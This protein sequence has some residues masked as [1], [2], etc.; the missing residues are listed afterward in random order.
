MGKAFSS[1]SQLG[2]ESSLG[3]SEGIVPEQTGYT[4]M[5]QNTSSVSLGPSKSTTAGI[6][7][8]VILL[9]VLLAGGPLFWRYKKRRAC[10]KGR[11][12]L[13][14]TDSHSTFGGEVKDI[15]QSAAMAVAA[16]QQQDVEKPTG[17]T[18]PDQ[19]YY[20]A[21]S[22]YGTAVTSPE[23]LHGFA[24]DSNI[25]SSHFSTSSQGQSD[26]NGVLSQYWVNDSATREE[27]IHSP[28]PMSPGNSEDDRTGSIL[29]Y[30]HSP[31]RALA[32][33]HLAQVAD[34]RFD[35][36]IASSTPSFPTTPVSASNWVDP[37]SAAFYAAPQPQSARVVRFASGVESMPSV[38]Y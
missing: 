27:R 21:E 10:R 11:L 15:Q 30:T 29:A 2:T 5:D 19:Y 16:E 24:T 23:H 33:G 17:Y 20:G 9:L 18:P 36:R 13:S 38:Y 4:P 34:R 32:T 7:V 8:G 1:H 12:S 28:L 22:Q 25:I 31:H 37:N 6:T 26:D 14:S 3:T 35:S